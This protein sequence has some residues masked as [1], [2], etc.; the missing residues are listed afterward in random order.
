MGDH[1][2]P[3]ETRETMEETM[4]DR[5][6]TFTTKRVTT[7]IG[8]FLRSNILDH[9]RL[10]YKFPWQS[11]THIEVYS[12]TDWAGCPRTR[13]STSG[14]AVM[15]GSHCIRTYSSTQTLVSLSSGEAEYYGLVKGCLL[16]T[17]P[18]PRDRG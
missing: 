17:S 15:I 10:V 12:D 9:K 4:G 18:S 7:L 1:V 5:I 11:A 13:K 14:G 16:Y 8:V 3:R 6:V 2:R